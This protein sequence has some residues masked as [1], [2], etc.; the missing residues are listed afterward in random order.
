MATLDFCYFPVT[1]E[2]DE[3]ESVTGYELLSESWG[4]G[5]FQVRG[6]DLQSFPRDT[7]AAQY[8]DLLTSLIPPSHGDVGFALVVPFLVFKC[9][10]IQYKV[11]S[12]SESWWRTIAHR[13]LWTSTL[14]RRE[15][16]VNGRKISE[17]E[18]LEIY[19]KNEDEKNKRKLL[20][21]SATTERV[22]A[23]SEGIRVVQQVQGLVHLPGNSK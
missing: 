10:N 1:D 12:S 21:P 6:S 7:K 4:E 9:Y 20:F 19:R 14:Q 18:G 22:A 5:Y 3:S 17:E 23:H 11:F 13:T 2:P 8:S 15:E 16:L